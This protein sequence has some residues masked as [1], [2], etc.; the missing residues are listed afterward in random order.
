MR[1]GVRKLFKDFCYKHN[2]M[3]KILLPEEKSNITGHI[4]LMTNI[5]T[6][7]YYI[8]QTRSHRLNKSKYRPFGYK[9]RFDDHIRY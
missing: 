6:K 3:D 8:G 2:I 7:K 5:I 1:N 9:K 4:Y